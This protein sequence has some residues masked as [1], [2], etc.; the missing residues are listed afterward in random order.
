MGNRVTNSQGS[1]RSR[2]DVRKDDASRLNVRE[3]FEA[4]AMSSK[5]LKRQLR[6][7]L[8]LKLHWRIIY[9]T[10]LMHYLI[11]Q[12]SPLASKGFSE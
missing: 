7:H 1:R 11:I 2:K 9:G 8:S 3:L 10:E 4:Q 5:D 6:T 12:K